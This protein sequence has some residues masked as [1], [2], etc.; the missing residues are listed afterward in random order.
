[1]D[2]QWVSLVDCVRTPVVSTST[3][4]TNSQ[5]FQPGREGFDA[6]CEGVATRG[7]R[8]TPLDRGRTEGVQ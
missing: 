1:M 3:K 7:F 4:P 5:E 6:L 2:S 8:S